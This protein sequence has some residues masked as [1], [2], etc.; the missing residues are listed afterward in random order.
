[1]KLPLFIEVAFVAFYTDLFT[2]ISA[3]FVC[4]KGLRLY[5]ASPRVFSASVGYLIALL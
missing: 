2:P 3:I 5:G 4:K 1:M